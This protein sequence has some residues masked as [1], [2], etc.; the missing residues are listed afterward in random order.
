MFNL[1]DILIRKLSPPSLAWLVRKMPVSALR[2]FANRQFRETL[3]WVNKHSPFY[4][5][6][7]AER[8]IDIRAIRKPEELGDFY[9]TPEDLTVNPADFICQKPSIVFESSGTSGKNK[10]I[11]Y[12]E[13][14]MRNTGTSTAAGYLLMGLNSTD[15]VA[16]AFDFSI[17]IPG[18][19]CHYGLMAAGIFSLDFGK[20]DPIEVYRRL[21]EY[22]FTAVFGEPTWLIRLTEL[23]EQMGPY[24]LKMILAQPKK[25]RRTQ[26]RGWKKSGRLRR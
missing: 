2:V 15:R 7:F 22:R 1:N 21:K 3:Q 16:N 13:Q 9:T 5:R 23:A 24:P 18:M 26:S 17:W 8:G 14:E 12:T 11:Y 20:V 19:I 4:R 10:Q 25:C 6:V